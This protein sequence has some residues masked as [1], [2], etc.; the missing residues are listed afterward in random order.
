MTIP[1]HLKPCAESLL[2]NFPAKDSETALTE[3][4]GSDRQPLN[5]RLLSMGD[6]APG[7]PA[8]GGGAAHF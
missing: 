6:G 1:G 4:T 2:K 8:G 3:A 7:T 5:S